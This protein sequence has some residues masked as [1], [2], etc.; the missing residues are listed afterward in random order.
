MMKQFII[1]TCKTLVI[2]TTL[3][4]AAL[5][6]VDVELQLL[7]DISGSI[8]GSEYD[9]QLLGYSNAFASDRV[10]NA[11]IEGNIGQIAVQMIMWSGANNQEIMIDWTLIDS[12]AASDDFSIAIANIARPFSGWTAIGSAI[13]YSYPLFDSNDFDGVSQVI[14]ISGDGTNNSGS[15]P[16]SA[17]TAALNHIDTING[18][19]ITDDQNVIDQ[20][21][22]DVIGGDSAFLLAPA[23]FDE[24]QLA[25]ENKIVAEIEGTVPAG[26]VSIPAPTTHLLYLTALI[27]LGVSTKTTRRSQHETA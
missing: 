1:N 7:I 16:S 15:S 25:I 18:I 17:A 6:P 5:T 19:V 8:D 9:T 26:V 4:A 27:M 21:Y 20:Y 13:E 14:D 10:Q 12:A 3:E 23:G 22:N 24:F 11:I 2:C